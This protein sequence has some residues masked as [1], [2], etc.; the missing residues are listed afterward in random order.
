MRIKYIYYCAIMNYLFSIIILY[1]LCLHAIVL[2]Y[3]SNDI[4][5]KI[6]NHFE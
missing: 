4:T 5:Y 2:Y 1:R 3:N 6:L